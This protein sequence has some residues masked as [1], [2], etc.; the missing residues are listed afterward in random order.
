MTYFFMTSGLCPGWEDSLDDSVGWSICAL[1]KC[2]VM[3]NTLLKVIIKMH[4]NALIKYYTVSIICYI[5]ITWL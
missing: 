1:H 5:I 3:L 4:Y 2:E